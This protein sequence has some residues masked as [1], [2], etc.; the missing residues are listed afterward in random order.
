MKQ[1]DIALL[2]DWLG[3]IGAVSGLEKSHLTNAELMAMARNLG[4]PTDAKPGRKQLSV[5]LV[6]HSARRID[7]PDD[8][9]L[10]M[11]PTELKRYIS[12]K[13]VSN[14]E[15]TEL[16]TRLGIA[17]TR[18]VRGRLVDFAAREIGDLGMY[19]RVARGSDQQ[20]F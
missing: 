14:T 11:S 5:E 12:E 20:V 7:R 2:I 6:M 10:A 17:P 13:L 16:L 9:L 19:Q 8:F 15:I 3:P 4:L 1:L 18:K